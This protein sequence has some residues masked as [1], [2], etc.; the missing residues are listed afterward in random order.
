[1]KTV[2]SSKR[3]HYMARVS[4]FLIMLTMV[5]LVVGMVSCGGRPAVNAIEIRT[6]YDLNAVGNNLSADYTLMNDLDRNTPGYTELASAT[7]NGGKG[8]QPI[9]IG[10]YPYFV[11]LF[12]GQGYEIRDLFINRP[13]EERVGLFSQITWFAIIRNVGV[14]NATVT[15]SSYV[16]SLVGYNWKNVINCY[17]SG[18]VIGSNRVGG[19][20]G[21]N[22]NTGTVS[23][24]YSTG[25]VTGGNFAGG[26]VGSNDGAVNN[27][28]AT[29]SVTGGGQV[30]GL[31][32]LA[33]GAVTDSYSTGDVAGYGVVGGLLG[34]GYDT[35]TVTNCY[36]TGSVT[37]E[38]DYVGG[39]VGSAGNV[40]DSYATGSVT[41][42]QSVG[43]LAGSAHA[44]SNCYA[45]GNV[46]GDNVIGGLVGWHTDGTV[47][48]S[49]ATG[50]V[51]GNYSG[52]LVGV[53]GEVW[54]SGGLVELNDNDSVAIYY[55]YS[56]GSVT[57]SDCIGGLVGENYHST[58]SNSYSSANVTG[59]SRVGGLVGWNAGNV[60]DSYATGSVA[61]NYSVGG[62][63]ADNLWGAV[64]NSFWDTE[65]SG[66]A[67]SDGGTGKTTAQMQDITTFSGATWDIIAVANPSIR[68]PS[69][70]WNIVDDETY[71][72]L[73]WQP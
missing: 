32:G 70:I 58:V 42:S 38:I 45:T 30:G 33:Y 53:N 67:T 31:V 36:A 26:L 52:G 64:A 73:S 4:I 44:V 25:S 54:V 47:S 19:L 65:T 5:T 71:P 27:C 41:G 6:W 35:S 59:A 60:N 57:G 21:G 66:Q 1:M 62:L 14:V 43:G 9:G 2:L 20:V 48:Y 37:G 17:F 72:F 51:T 56:T 69:Y 16:G 18:N 55:C 68:N 12:D 50:S 3:H 34:L 7:A 49:Y 61:G 10:E 13:E 23:D 39:L 15:G 8:W 22:S 63:V 24:C 29:G 40:S 11:G 46:T 28:W